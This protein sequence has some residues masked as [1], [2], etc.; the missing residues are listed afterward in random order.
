VLRT[1]GVYTFGAYPDVDIH[2]L[3]YESDRFD[4]EIHSDTLE[5]VNNPV[6]ALTESR[7]V[8]KPDVALC[9]NRADNCWRM[10]RDRSACH[11]A[12]TATQAL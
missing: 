5:H 2:S 9:F 12:T 11:P 3:P 7:R 10:S 4:V 8:L 6:Q 1:L